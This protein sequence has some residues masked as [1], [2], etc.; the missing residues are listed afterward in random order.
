MS[1]NNLQSQVSLSFFLSFFLAKP[2][3][4]WTLQLVALELITLQVNFFMLQDVVLFKKLCRVE[5]SICCCPLGGLIL[6]K[7]AAPKKRLSCRPVGFPDTRVF[8]LQLLQWVF[9]NQDETWDLTASMVSENIPAK[10]LL[11]SLQVNP[12]PCQPQK[13]AGH[14]CTHNQ[15]K[16]RSLNTAVSNVEGRVNAL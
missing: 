14:G 11:I 16:Q 5:G 6:H 10:S 8:F 9:N 2:L 4:T 12:F 1:R 15:A 3:G 7:I 13:P